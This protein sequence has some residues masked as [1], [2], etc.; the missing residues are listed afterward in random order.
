[1]HDKI[2]SEQH[3]VGQSILLHLMP[4]LLITAGYFALIGPLQR[5]G[6]PSIMALTVAAI[7]LLIPVQLGYLLVQGKRLNG[8]YSLQGVIS[9]RRPLPFKQ[10]LLWVPVLFVAAG[11]IFTLFKPVNL[12]LQERVFA[13]WPTLQS[14]LEGGFA[15]GP[16]IAT[17]VLVAIFVT[18]IGPTVEELYFRGYLLP[19]MGYV[20]KWAPLLHSFLFALYHFFTP[21]MIVTRTLAML[22]M[23]YAV[24]R[25]NIT[26]SIIVH[27]LLNS[28]DVFAAIAFI[29]T[30]T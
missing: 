8:R 16:L 27:V 9:Y 14:G 25:K 22:P 26:L 15:K 18:V 24:Q 19:R 12:F 21:W 13:A 28:L 2:Q 5:A 6:Y 4:G 7:F 29:M 23:I 11:L 20:G 17:Y 30:M 1:M 10:Y 3:S